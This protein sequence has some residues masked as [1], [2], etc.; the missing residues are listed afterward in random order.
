[1]RLTTLL[2]IFLNFACIS[3]P[4]GRPRSIAERYAA[5]VKVLTLCGENISGGSGTILDDGRVLTAYH[6]VEC[7]DLVTFQIAVIAPDSEEPRMM[8]LDKAAEGKDVAVLSIETGAP[9][10]GFVAP[11]FGP[12]PKVG[13]RVCIAH[14]V[15][16]IGH[17][18]GEVQ[19]YADM[20]APGD[21]VHTAITD[22]GNSGSGVYDSVG[23]LIGVVTHLITCSNGQICGGKVSTLESIQPL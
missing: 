9:F 13:E 17:K 5:S 6:V 23:R 4:L 8:H 18:C 11:K 14:S 3:T 2:F 22:H 7:D 21:L 10:A 1:M 20:D 16:R 15:P 12:L 19:P